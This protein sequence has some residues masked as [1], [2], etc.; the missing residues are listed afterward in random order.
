MTPA[1][2]ILLQI[3]KEAADRNISIGKTQLIKLLYLAEVEYFREKGERLTD[4]DWVFYYYGPYEF[5]LEGILESEEFDRQEIKTSS[6]KDYI[7]FRVSE[8]SRKYGEY[9]D[10]AVSVL[11]KKILGTWGRC[12]LPELLNYVYFE[13]EPMEDVK[14]GDRLQFEKIDRTSQPSVTPL[15][16]SSATNKKIRELRAR[17]SERLKVIGREKDIHIHKDKDELEA[18]R[19]WDGG[20][21]NPD[22][23]NIKVSFIPPDDK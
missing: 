17:V 18:I 2:D 22:L 15:E 19:E 13:T 4:I 9:T 3:L 14:R 11:L 10:A 1:K 20:D 7:K 5:E 21:E 23:K 6:D 8:K 16:A 12:E